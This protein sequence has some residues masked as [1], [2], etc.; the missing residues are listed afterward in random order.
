MPD[1]WSRTVT[2]VTSSAG[3][4]RFTFEKIHDHILGEDV[5]RRS[6]GELSSELLNVIRDKKYQR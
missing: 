2:A 1:C 3:S 6:Y 5:R 4:D